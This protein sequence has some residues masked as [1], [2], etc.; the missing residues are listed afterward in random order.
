[1]AKYE[2]LRGDADSLQVISGRAW[3]FGDRVSAGQILAAEYAEQ[4][5]ATAGRHAL[6]ALDSRFANS[7]APGDCIVAGI[8]FAFDATHRSVPAALKALGLG[9]VIARSF[10]PFFLRNAIHLGLPA[11]IVEETAAVRGGDHLRV[12]IEAHVVA[13]LSSGDRYVIRNIDDD[14]LAVLRKRQ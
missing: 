14:A 12:D 13:N 1:M 10:G 3:V 6:A 7:V 5:V 11:L 4:P 8:D 9:A 2:D